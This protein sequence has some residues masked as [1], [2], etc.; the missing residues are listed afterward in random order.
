MNNNFTSENFP[1]NQPFPLIDNYLT[2]EGAMI[3]LNIS[4]CSY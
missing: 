3:K 2:L 1:R 4:F